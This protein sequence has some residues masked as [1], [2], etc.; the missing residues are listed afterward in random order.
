M[1]KNIELIKQQKCNKRLSRILAIILVSLILLSSSFMVV[2][3]AASNESDIG[4]QSV[5]WG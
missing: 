5:S 3:A 2:S 1:Y 4:A